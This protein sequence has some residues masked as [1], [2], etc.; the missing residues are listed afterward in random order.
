MDI[1]KTIEAKSDQLNAIDF[2]AGPEVVTITEVTK[3]DPDQPVCIHVAE[4]PGKPFKPSKTVRRVLVSGWGADASQY[5]GRSLEL[6]NDQSVKWAGEAVGGIRVSGMSH[7]DKPLTLSLSV[8]RGKRQKYTIKPLV[9]PKPLPA[10]DKT[11]GEVIPEDVLANVARAK[12]DGN[13]PA[14]LDYLIEKEAPAHILTYV[15]EQA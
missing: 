7:I 2:V 14:Y 8:S 12:A 15:K 5:I 3:G 13:L 11:T 9:A 4:H 10:A 1:S 6:F